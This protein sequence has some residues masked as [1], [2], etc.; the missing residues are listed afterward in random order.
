MNT[1]YVQNFKFSETILTIL[2]AQIKLKKG[3]VINIPAQYAALDSAPQNYGS[4]F[5]RSK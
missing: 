3:T 4:N 5:H 2:H 1:T